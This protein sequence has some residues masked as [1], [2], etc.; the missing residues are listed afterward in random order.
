MTD[1]QHLAGVHAPQDRYPSSV[2]MHSFRQT[3]LSLVFSF[4]CCCESSGR[5]LNASGVLKGFPRIYVKLDNNIH[6]TLC[7][8]VGH[9]RILYFLSRQVFWS[10]NHCC[11]KDKVRQQKSCAYVYSYTWNSFSQGLRQ[12]NQAV[13]QLFPRYSFIQVTKA[14]AKWS[15]TADLVSSKQSTLLG[16][17]SQ[18]VDLIGELMYFPNGLNILLMLLFL[19]A[20]YGTAWEGWSCTDTIQR[21]KYP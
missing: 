18:P 11:L 5:C 19:L 21:I 3:L 7:F 17:L 1:L 16:G 13:T 2:I 15:T 20:A 9:M 14:L 8:R 12:A 10:S 4:F 6:P